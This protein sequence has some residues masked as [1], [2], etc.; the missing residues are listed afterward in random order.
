MVSKN[1]VF[2]IDI[3]VILTI[4]ALVNIGQGQQQANAVQGGPP[5]KERFRV[6]IFVGD[7]IG[8]QGQKADVCVSVSDGQH[9]CK[10]NVT[11][12]FE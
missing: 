9:F 7:D 8:A 1:N 11:G 6:D 5:G 12:S 10:N 3:I 2:V 4:L